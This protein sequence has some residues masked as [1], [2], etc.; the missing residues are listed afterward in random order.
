MASRTSNVINNSI[1]RLVQR[2][3][4]IFVQFV[5]RTVFIYYLGKEYTG[6]SGLFTDILNVLSLME[7]GLDSSMIY[8]L[9]KP[10]AEKDEKRIKQLLNFYKKAF[11]VIG[12]VVFIIGFSLIPFLD[13]IVKNVPNIEEDIRLIFAF[14]IV[15]AASSYFFIYRSVLL[16]AD[17]KSRI[18]SKWRTII[19][20]V[21]CI[22]AV[23]FI[24]IF[25]NFIV[26]LIIHLIA[27]VMNNVVISIITTRMYPEYFTKNNYQLSKEE[28]IKILKDILYLTAYS[29]S[30][31]IINSTDSIFISAFVGTVQVAIIGNFTLIVNSIRTLVSQI[32]EVTK[33]SIGNLAATTNQ[34]SQ[35]IVF[36]KMNFIS[37]YVATIFSAALF[38][39][40]NPFIGDIWLD[41]SFKVE[42]FIV[43]L[44]VINLY[45]AIMVFPIEAFRTANGLFKQGWVRPII[46]AVLNI[47]LDF[48]MGKRFGIAG[49]FLATTISRFATQVWYDPYLVYKLVFKKTHWKFLLN[50]IVRLLIAMGISLSSYFIIKSLALNNSLI[51]FIVKGIL[52]LLISNIMIFIIYHNNKD[53]RYLLNFVGH[54]LARNR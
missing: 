9:Y 28:S 38:S 44:I 45:I 40:L 54:K 27:S 11:I 46:M 42:Q 1:A 3:L 19:T 47:I 37:F 24:V 21:E 14:Y 35:E 20:V 39:L 48:I 23:I 25:K 52:S 26:Y 49:I 17:Q 53:Y 15:T 43:A 5:I 32:V 4:S 51:L 7:I 8:S 10:L 41:P 16:N 6:V 30:G 50:Y 29:F 31:V 33:P 13:D 12:T 18:I 2:F 22:V 36:D 34:N